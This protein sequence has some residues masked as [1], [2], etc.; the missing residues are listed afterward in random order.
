MVPTLYFSVVTRDNVIIFGHKFLAM[1]RKAYVITK[2]G[3][4]LHLSHEK[5][6]SVNDRN[7]ANHLTQAL[8][9][10]HQSNHVAICGNFVS[11]NLS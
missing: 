3:S 9:F 4:L 8:D 11:E 2:P 6:F 1:A 7:S 5:V 10:D